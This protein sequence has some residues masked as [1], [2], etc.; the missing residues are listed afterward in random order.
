MTN[1]CLRAPVAPPFIWCCAKGG[2][3]TNTNG[4]RLSIRAQD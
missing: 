3:G 1:I 2:G 4:R